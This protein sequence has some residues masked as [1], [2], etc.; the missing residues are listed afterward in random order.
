MYIIYNI[1]DIVGYCSYQMILKNT[2]ILMNRRLFYTGLA[3]LSSMAI[4]LHHSIDH[5][6]SDTLAPGTA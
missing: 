1:D 5:N 6:I 4:S 2:V 3:Y